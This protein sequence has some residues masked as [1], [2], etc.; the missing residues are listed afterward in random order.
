MGKPVGARRVRQLLDHM[1]RK[2]LL[3]QHKELVVGELDVK[4]RELVEGELP[5]DDGR[6]P[7]HLIAFRRETIEPS[8]DHLLDSL[9]QPNAPVSCLV[10]RLSGQRLLLHQETDDLG[11]EEGIPLGL[12]VDGSGQLGGRLQADGRLDEMCDLLL[13]QA[14]QRHALEEP[15]ACQLGK[16]V[17][18]RV[19]PGQL[20]VDVGAD[21]EQTR[22]RELAGDELEQQ[23]RP[24]VRA[25]EVIQDDHERLRARSPLEEERERIEEPEACLRGIG[26][27]RRELE[28]G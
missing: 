15:L 13:R 22:P 12:P 7:K 21:E 4:R 28:V 10:E 27:G 16:R 11:H 25:V 14:A 6:E 19:S 3:E 9:G 23:Q 18:K 5:A 1:S 2:R 20:H 17:G 26:W 24:G 8:A